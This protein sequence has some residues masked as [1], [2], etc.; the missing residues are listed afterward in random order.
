MNVCRS[1]FAFP[2]DDA[3]HLSPRWVGKLITRLLPAELTM[4]TLRHRFASRAWS[5]GVDIWVLQSILGHAS[6]D[7]TRRYVA[8]PKTAERSAIEGLSRVA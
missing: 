5:S 2:G 1:G 6:S 8:I 3:G 7:T 4:H